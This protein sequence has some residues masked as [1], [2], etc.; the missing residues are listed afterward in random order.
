MRRWTAIALL[1]AMTAGTGA[2]AQC[3]GFALTATIAPDTALCTGDTAMI[4]VSGELTAATLQW[5]DSTTAWTDIPGATDDTL[6]VSPVGTAYFRC[7]ASCLDTSTFSDTVRITVNPRPIV[8][9]TDTEEPFYCGAF[10]DTLTASGA[11]FYS[12]IPITGLTPTTGDTVVGNVTGS[13][14]YVVVG[15]DL[16]GCSDTD[17]VSI[18]VLERPTVTFPEDLLICASDTAAS[19]LFLFD[20]AAPFTITAQTPTGTT[21]TTG[22]ASDSLIL[23]SLLAGDYLITLSDTGCAAI[24]PVA[25][26]VTAVEPLAGISAIAD[27]DT[28]CAQNSSDLVGNDPGAFTGI[29]S[30]V[31]GSGPGQVLPVN[32]S[33][34]VFTPDSVGTY[35]LQW[36]IFGSICPDLRDTVSVEVVGLA[37]P[38]NA[39]P[40]TSIC[41]D[42]SLS[43]FANDPS[44]GIGTWSIVS[45]PLGVIADIHSHTSD[46]TPSS[47]GVYTLGWSIDN[48]PCLAGSDQLTITVIEPDSLP[49]IIGLDDTTACDGE[50]QTFIVQGDSRPATWQ[51]S[52]WETQQIAGDTV[53]V[54]WS[55]PG[56]STGPVA[57]TINLTLGGGC[58]LATSFDM[59][60]LSSPASCPKGIVYFE[61]QGLAIIDPTARYFQWGRLEGSVFVADAART[62]QTTFDAGHIQGCGPSPYYVVRSSIDGAQ[63][64]STTLFCATAETLARDCDEGDM[65]E[66]AVRLRVYPDPSYGGPV[67]IE[68]IGRSELP[69]RIDV[70]DMN[71]RS[72]RSGTLPLKGVSTLVLDLDHLQ[73]GVYV[74]RAWNTDFDRAIKLVID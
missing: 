16:N 14:T 19:L 51:C 28:I 47:A 65:E 17:S 70:S 22:Y 57:T 33:T 7:L 46:F 67:T 64:W 73:R 72:L 58:P 50:Y 74:L 13:I 53:N 27:E 23:S 43:L 12:W 5:Q 44:P 10:N 32:D 40:D 69:L 52:N 25:V 30:I 56:S 11:E 2:K 3:D 24:D 41:A 36:T 66:Q 48:S 42:L 21:T 39:G 26:H 59:Q 61:P 1:L 71:G 49:A 18:V 38:A 54:H 34:A 55:Y 9:V 8:D 29:W 63:C 4:I 6:L 62:D 37:T 31:P 45:G 15:T 35:Q 60:L 20:G 68:A